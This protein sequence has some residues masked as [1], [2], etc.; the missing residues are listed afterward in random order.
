MPALHVAS[1]RGDVAS[2]QSLLLVKGGAGQPSAP[3][4]M[5]GV[6]GVAGAAGAVGAATAAAEVDERGPSGWT[7]LMEASNRGHLEAVSLL[8]S[9]GADVNASSVGPSH[10]GCTAL[11]R[12]AGRGH[13][14]VVR[15]LL[16]AHADPGTEKVEAQAAAQARATGGYGRVLSP[17]HEA[18]LGGYSDIV[19]LLLAAQKGKEVGAGTM[20]GALFI[21]AQVGHTG[22]IKVLLEGG[23]M[24]HVNAAS[25]QEGSGGGDGD[26]HTVE[27]EEARESSLEND[28]RR[29]SKVVGSKRGN[30]GGWGSRHRG[31]T[32]LYV[33]AQYGNVGAVSVLL[34]AGAS[35]DRDDEYGFT[36]LYSAA[37]TGRIGVLRL[38][39]KYGADVNRTNMYGATALHVA[40]RHGHVGAAK[41]LWLE[42]GADPNAANV[43]GV[44]PLYTAARL[45]H[46]DMV[47]L[48][49]RYTRTRGRG[50]KEAASGGGGG[51]GGGQGGPEEGG[52]RTRR[53]GRGGGNG[54]GRG[55]GGDR[56]NPDAVA[57]DG[58]TPLYRAAEIGA[59]PIVEL[60]LRAG[61]NVHRTVRSNH[62]QA[63]KRRRHKGVGAD[64]AD[65]ADEADGADGADEVNAPGN[66]G[67]GT[68]ADDGV[69][70]L[71]VAA[72]NGHLDMVLR[73]LGEGANPD[74]ATADD[75]STALHIATQNGH[76][77]VVRALVGGGGL[78]LILWIV[79]PGHRCTL[80]P[81]RGSR[82][83]CKYLCGRGRPLT[84]RASR[85][86]R[87]CS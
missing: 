65:G 49:L 87:H 24:Q 62:E 86:P 3:V 79:A 66:Q 11:V 19:R 46:V 50:T 81:R 61:A 15:A 73:I 7:A 12:A 70:A 48:L 54:R 59:M 36:P 1:L 67:A 63:L 68:T 35:V 80:R 69:T 82:I 23:G 76:I 25:W 9:R 38:L 60:L 74:Q 10:W 41:V 8:L 2:V 83:S 21:A 57:V 44:T 32:A 47:R 17:L 72:Q 34:D 31:F 84:A 26:E 51:G 71:Y 40:A 22:T 53:G 27:K 58:T 77:E 85:A 42:G 14:A 20:I 37:M 13:M 33:A 78:T 5:P 30:R 18:A 6:A 45:G 75:R 43:L 64:G 55:G 28:G 29:Q 39:L 16:A 52:G 56:V 4:S